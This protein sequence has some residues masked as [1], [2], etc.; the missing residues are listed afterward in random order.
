M[1]RHLHHIALEVIAVLVNKSLTL[2]KVRITQKQNRLS[3]NYLLEKYAGAL[4]LWLSPE[5]VR[6]LPIGDDQAEYAEKVRKT[7]AASGIRVKCDTRNEKIGYKIRAAQLE[8]IPYMLVIGEKEMQSGSVAVRERAA[9][10]IGTMT[11]E[12]FLTRAVEENVKK[13]IK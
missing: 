8:K 13:V 6:I 11:I 7:L 3:F 10:D 9:G 1:V 5:Q 2:E 4:P 12:E